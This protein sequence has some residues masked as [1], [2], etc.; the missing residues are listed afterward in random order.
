MMNLN[1]A[2]AGTLLDGIIAPM[3]WS[4]PSASLRVLMQVPMLI[5]GAD[6]SVYGFTVPSSKGIALTWSQTCSSGGDCALLV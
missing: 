2:L 6:L 3:S 5:A 1:V 4:S